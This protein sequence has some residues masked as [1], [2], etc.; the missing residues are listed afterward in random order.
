MMKIPVVRSEYKTQINLTFNQMWT[1]REDLGLSDVDDMRLT[2]TEAFV[3][4]VQEQAEIWRSEQ[5]R[6]ASCVR[7]RVPGGQGSTGSGLLGQA[8]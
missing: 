6:T 5:S 3:A 2:V 7:I 4:R 1:L 8:A